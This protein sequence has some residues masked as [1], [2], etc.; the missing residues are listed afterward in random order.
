M[1][2][3]I[4]QGYEVKY[5]SESTTEKGRVY[6]ASD[7]LLYPSVTTI[8]KHYENSKEL[9]AW[10]ERLGKEESERIANE[11]AQRG[12]LTH[13]HI[14]NYLHNK[15]NFSS[16]KDL[17]EYLNSIDNVFATNAINYFYKRVENINSEQAIFYRDAYIRYAGRYD[18]L[19]NIK[20]NTFFFKNSSEILPNGIALVDLKTKDKLPRLDK[21]DYLIK[22][23][24]QGS[25]YTNAIEKSSDI[26]INYFIIVFSSPKKSV[27]LLFTKDDLD[28]Y[29]DEFYKF[30]CNFFDTSKPIPTWKN[31]IARAS[32]RYIWE[33]MCYI[34]SIPREIKPIL[35]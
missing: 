17:D 29:Y 30:A 34:D 26:K 16:E 28:F 21:V 23:A 15:A 14:D 8:L 1:S 35:N 32:S 19:E 20:D 27:C 25:A 31:V 33:D 6:K 5:I 24:L 7:N 9:I 4:S 2:V 13:S 18:S 11:A 12:I 3:N 22:Y 10:K